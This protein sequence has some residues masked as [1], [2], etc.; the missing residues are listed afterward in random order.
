MA[1][2][3]GYSANREPIGAFGVL[4]N[5][6]TTGAG[7]H[8]IA[9]IRGNVFGLAFNAR[10]DVLANLT[11]A[12]LTAADLDERGILRQVVV[13]NLDGANVIELSAWCDQDTGADLIPGGHAEVG[14][15]GA[16]ASFTWHSHI[17]RT[18]FA[19]RCTAVATPA[20][21]VEIRFDVLPV[22]NT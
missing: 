2:Q 15:D 18:V 5:A 8:D 20:A 7:A 3:P 10:A 6:I 1:G 11:N 19:I 16:V 4:I 14:V 12:G 9:D 22:E 21:N 13:Q 17:A